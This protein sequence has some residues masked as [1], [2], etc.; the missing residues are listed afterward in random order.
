MKINLKIKRQEKKWFAWYPVKMKDNSF[1]W[2]EKVKRTPIYVDESFQYY[3]Y[4]ELLEQNK[5][6]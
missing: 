6:L 3:V 5:I 2:L 1:V 4:E